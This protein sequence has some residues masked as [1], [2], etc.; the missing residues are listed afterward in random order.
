MKFERGSIWIFFR[1]YPGWQKVVESWYKYVDTMFYLISDNF[2]QVYDSL[3]KY[4]FGFL[5]MKMA[6]MFFWNWW[7][8]SSFRCALYLDS[9]N[10]EY[11]KRR[12]LF[13][14]WLSIANNNVYFTFNSAVEYRFLI[15]CFQSLRH[16]CQLA[17]HKGLYQ[18][19]N[20]AN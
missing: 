19:N 11:I 18:R 16:C 20:N 14:N 10:P 15:F 6:D 1:S 8:T 5:Y 9:F 17:E 2:E 7:N 12:T 3:E 4:F 13:Q